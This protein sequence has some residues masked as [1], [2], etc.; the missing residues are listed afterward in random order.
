MSEMAERGAK[1][2]RAEHKA[3]YPTGACSHEAA[4][5][6]ALR[7]IASMREPTEAQHAA[8]AKTLDWMSDTPLGN[9]Q[10][11]AWREE[12][13]KRWQLMVGAALQEDKP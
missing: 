9:Q 11:Q 13:T 3:S 7:V 4:S 1:A 5:R 10:R 6:I 8:F 2:V 12:N